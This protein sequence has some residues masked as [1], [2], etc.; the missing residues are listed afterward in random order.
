MEKEFGTE[1]PVGCHKVQWDD[2][3]PGQ[4]SCDMEKEAFAIQN[5]V[6]GA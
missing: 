1:G 5:V 3:D 6:H 4:G 2:V